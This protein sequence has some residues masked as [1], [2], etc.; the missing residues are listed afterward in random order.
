MMLHPLEILKDRITESETIESWRLIY[1]E[2]IRILLQ[3]IPD[4]DSIIPKLNMLKFRY[5]T[6]LNVI[7][8]DDTMQHRHYQLQDGRLQDNRWLAGN[9]VIDEVIG[10]EKFLENHYRR[11]SIV[12][13][14]AHILEMQDENHVSRILTAGEE[15]WQT[16]KTKIT[17]VFDKIHGIN[18][19]SSWDQK[20]A[21]MLH[22]ILW[23][24]Y[25]PSKIIIYE[26]RPEHFQKA[27]TALTKLLWWTE[28]VVNHVLL[29]QREVIKKQIEEIRQW[30]YVSK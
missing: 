20:I 5:G 16:S 2:D 12:R 25:I 4:L 9:K 1:P 27:A 14:I 22:M 8:Y 17:G 21:K 19:V 30:I 3:Y 15:T 24:W 18:I 13:R 6:T 23:L 26:D 7:D 10:R 29:S 28:I 11:D